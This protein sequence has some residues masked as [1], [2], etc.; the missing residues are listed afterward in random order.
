VANSQHATGASNKPFRRTQFV[1]HARTDPIK[2]GKFVR[3]AIARSVA[4]LFLCA[5]TATAADLNG[6]WLAQVSMRGR[7]LTDF[8]FN[9]KVDGP[10][11]TGTVVYAIADSLWK[12]EIVDGKVSGTDLSFA[13]LSKQRDT[14]QRWTFKGKLQDNEIEFSMQMPSSPAPAGPPPGGGAPA[15][16]GAG[17][18]P[19]ATAGGSNPAPP[20]A[21]PGGMVTLDFVAKKH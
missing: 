16:P 8:F 6:Q 19:A 5:S 20:A 3:T 13:V 17:A 15:A 21:G 12:M 10:K 7:D 4:L 2:G 11:L 14:E 18:P 9:F 1:Y